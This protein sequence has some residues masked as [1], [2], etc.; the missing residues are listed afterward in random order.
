MEEGGLVDKISKLSRR[1]VLMREALH[2]ALLSLQPRVVH[3]WGEKKR[4][5]IERQDKLMN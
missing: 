5:K 4:K 2:G 3:L 1:H